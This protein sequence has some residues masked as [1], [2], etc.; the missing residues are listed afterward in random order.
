MEQMEI[1]EPMHRKE[2]EQ[3]IYDTVQ[4]T[5]EDCKDFRDRMHD[6]FLIVRNGATI[7]DWNFSLALERR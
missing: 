6:A 4:A 3:A 2:A 7:L 1:F 5:R